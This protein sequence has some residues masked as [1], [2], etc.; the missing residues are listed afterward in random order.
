MLT[1]T[2]Y[3]SGFGKEH[4]LHAITDAHSMPQ[5][6]P[7]PFQRAPIPYIRKRLLHIA[8]RPLY[9]LGNVHSLPEIA[10]C[11]ISANSKI[12]DIIQQNLPSTAGLWPIEATR[13]LCRDQKNSTVSWIHLREICFRWWWLPTTERARGRS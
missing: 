2:F 3:I 6:T 4:P 8:E 13:D 11:L 10:R 9:V 1:E 12:Q 5:G 7:T